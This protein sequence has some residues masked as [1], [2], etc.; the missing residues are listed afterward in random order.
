MPDSLDGPLCDKWLQ[1]GG[2]PH[3]LYKAVFYGRGLYPVNRK[4]FF[5]ILQGI[6]FLSLMT[7][8]FI[9][10]W[11]VAALLLSLIQFYALSRSRDNNKVT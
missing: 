5:V 1:L 11:H 4:I 8:F 10:G 7:T 6:I 9:R 2:K 3:T